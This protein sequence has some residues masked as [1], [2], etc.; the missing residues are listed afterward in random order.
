M[1]E[2]FSSQQA[3]IRRIFKSASTTELLEMSNAQLMNQAVLKHAEI[4]GVT[5]TETRAV[6]SSLQLLI[7]YVVDIANCMTD[8]FNLGVGD[9]EKD[10]DCERVFDDMLYPT[11]IV[12]TVLVLSFE[13]QVRQIPTKCPN[14]R[15][16]IYSSLVAAY[17]IA[18]KRTTQFPFPTPPPYHSRT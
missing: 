5:S 17:T 14:A 6:R 16:C 4:I 11:A 7:N 15:A 12:N 2:F 10:R 8:L 18:R 3:S 1:N 13:A 9:T